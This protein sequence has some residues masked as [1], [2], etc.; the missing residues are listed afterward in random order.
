[1]QSAVLRRAIRPA[2]I[3]ITAMLVLTN[4]GCTMAPRSER[5]ATASAVPLVNT[6]WRLTNLGERVIDNPAGGN[7]VALQLQPSNLRLTGF[8]GCNRMFGGYLLNAD[9]LKFDQVG[10]TKMACAEESRMKLEQE[11]FQ[12][13]SAVARWKITG[14]SL[15]LMDSGGTTVATFAAAAP[16]Q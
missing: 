11:Y 10:A 5:V 9:Q 12:M 3:L 15:E 1:M 16:D 6:N 14:S 7:A 8:A 2:V 13:L 4:S